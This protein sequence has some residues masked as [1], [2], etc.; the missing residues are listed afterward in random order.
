[1]GGGGWGFATGGPPP[2]PWL[3]K[4]SAPLVPEHVGILPSH[5]HGQTKKDVGLRSGRRSQGALVTLKT[6]TALTNQSLSGTQGSVDN[7]PPTA[8]VEYAVPHE[9]TIHVISIFAFS[10]R[11]NRCR[12]TG[13]G[14]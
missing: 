4:F 5:L 9:A 10:L 1:M 7:T 13:T 14:R 6:R 12:G 2:P 11:E 3:G 8:D